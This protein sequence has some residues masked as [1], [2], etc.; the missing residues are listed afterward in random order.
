MCGARSS[1]S[2]TTS[3]SGTS[4]GI[5]VR[6]SASAPDDARPSPQPRRPARARPWPRPGSPGRS[7]GR[8]PSR[9]PARPAAS[10]R[11]SACP[12]VRPDAHSGRAT[13]LVRRARE[14]RPALGHRL[15]PE[16]DRRVHQQ[17]HTSLRRAAGP[18]RR[19]AGACPPRG[20]PTGSRRTRAS[21]PRL[22]PAD[23][24]ARPARPGRSRPP[25]ARRGPRRSAPPPG[26]PRAAR[27]SAP[28]RRPRSAGPRGP[29]PWPAQHALVHRRRSG[30]GEHQLVR[31]APEQL[32]H[33]LPG[34]VQQHPGPAPLPV[35]PVGS[36]PALLQRGQVRLAP[37]RIQRLPARRVQIHHGIEPRPGRAC[38][39]A[40]GRSLMEMI[41]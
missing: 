10:P 33:R 8:A 5:R 25:A 39:A 36:G 3:T 19:P 32:G 2:P 38:R 31:A 7:P 12:C 18:P 27:S 21:G 11:R 15:A 14:H 13:P 6:S 41:E 35:E 22:G 28:P 37:G 4:S 40:D 23:R 20:S 29:G 17:R 1:G 24:P 26:P 30:R 34:R 9:V 16:R